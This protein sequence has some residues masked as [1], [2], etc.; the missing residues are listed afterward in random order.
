MYL[1]YLR[2]KKQLT[3]VCTPTQDGSRHTQEQCLLFL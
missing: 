2:T 1:V 3:S